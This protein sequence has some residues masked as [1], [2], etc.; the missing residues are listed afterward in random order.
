[1]DIKALAIAIISTSLL[2]CS[3]SA[4]YDFSPAEQERIEISQAYVKACEAGKTSWQIG[5]HKIS[6]EPYSAFPDIYE[7]NSSKRV[8]GCFVFDAFNMSPQETQLLSIEDY[9][10]TLTEYQPP[11]YRPISRITGVFPAPWAECKIK[12]IC[13]KISINIYVADSPKFPNHRVSEKIESLGDMRL[14]ILPIGETP[15]EMTWESK[16]AFGPKII[17]CSN[18]DVPGSKIKGCTAV[19]VLSVETDILAGAIILIDPTKKEQTISKI[20]TTISFIE[21]LWVD[22]KADDFRQIDRF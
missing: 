17:D 18:Q 5:D 11:Q 6:Y 15:E 1:L 9:K 10:R 4:E 12:T 3:Q 8:L 22:L 19:I 2:S 20:E 13:Q 21:D 14:L 7:L 16:S